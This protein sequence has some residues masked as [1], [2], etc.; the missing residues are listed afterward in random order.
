MKTQ[1]LNSYDVTQYAYSH[2]LRLCIDD[3][4]AGLCSQVQPTSAR[5]SILSRMD[6]LRAIANKQQQN[7]K[8][9]YEKL[10]TS[11]CF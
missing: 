8:A 10:Q 4:K 3:V 6:R 1:L 2:S 9:K 11:F 5:D 7:K